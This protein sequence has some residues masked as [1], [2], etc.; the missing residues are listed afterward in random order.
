MTTK[1]F[2]SFYHRVKNQ[3]KSILNLVLKDLMD[4]APFTALGALTGIF[5]VGLVSCVPYLHSISDSLFWV[6]HP[7]HVFLSALVT[8]GIYRLHN[9]RYILK[10]CVVGY[11]GSIGIGTLSDCLIPYIGEF[12]WDLPNRE[13]HIGFIEKWWLVNPLA[14]L[15]I[16]LAFFKPK[17]KIPHAGHVLL[18]TWA[19]LF[20]IEMAIISTVD[21]NTTLFIVVFLFLSVWIPCCTSDIVF[22][23]LFVKEKSENE[24]RTNF[25]THEDSPAAQSFSN[26]VKTIKNKNVL[27]E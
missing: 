9:N 1:V 4:H 7:F 26:I 3:N 2:D 19:S 24:P 27:D 14:A 20:H 22:P 15:G 25:K 21:F 13:L 16:L 23:L 18:S 8:T 17:T 6:L 5:M 11:L 12:L 10:A